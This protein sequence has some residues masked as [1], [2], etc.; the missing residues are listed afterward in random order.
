MVGTVRER[1]HSLKSIYVY[2]IETL[3]CYLRGSA[4]HVVTCARVSLHMCGERVDG[5]VCET[6]ECVR[7]QCCQ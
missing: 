6:I 5:S 7:L 3:C 2:E 1:N 4:H